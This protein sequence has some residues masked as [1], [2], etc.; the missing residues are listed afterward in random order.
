MEIILLM[1][2]QLLTAILV[3]PLFDGI[4]NNLRAKIQSRKGYPILQTYY[5]IFKLL[6]RSSSAPKCSHWFFKFAPFMLFSIC[7]LLG[8]IIPITYGGY[9]KAGVISDI[10]VFIYLV[11]MFRFV[12]GI[13]SL[14][15][16]NAF[17]GVGASRENLIAVYVE[18]ILII[19]L[20]IV[21]MLA[22]TT[23]LP[24]I[25]LTLQNNYFGYHL[26][27]YSIC[28]VVFLW[29]MYVETGR[30]P[31]DQAE[32]EQEL[33]EGLI[34]E[35]SGKNLALMHMS[36]MLKQF[37]M[38]SFFIAIFIPWSFTNP[39]LA[40]IANLIEVGIFYIGAVL[41]DNFGPRFKMVSSLR[42]N[43][44][45]ILLIAFFALILYIIGV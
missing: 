40:L 8:M 3:I 31:F 16:A 37:A 22:Q 44:A 21:S 42:S 20:I 41:I 43:S 11:A 30:K 2:L 28:S 19:C 45:Y 5:D 13:A 32:A 6:K 17:A 34:G 4:A 29:A 14:D 27:S 23:N 18:P 35:Y 36:M 10:F 26:A 39:F 24:M 25:K 12:F 9:Y 38:I 33:G 7:A 15:S 1:I